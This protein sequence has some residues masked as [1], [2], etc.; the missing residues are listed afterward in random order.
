M[1]APPAPMTTTLN[2]ASWP[3]RS[4]EQWL[5]PSIVTRT[6]EGLLTSLSILALK[7]RQF[8]AS[9]A[10]S[11]PAAST[12][13]AA[14]VRKTR[15][16]PPRKRCGI[17]RRSN[18]A[19][20]RHREAPG[21]TLGSGVDVR[22]RR[23]GAVSRGAVAHDRDGTLPGAIPGAVRGV[24]RAGGVGD[25]GHPRASGGLRRLPAA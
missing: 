1:T 18:G 11:G 8:L 21:S 7:S 24:G 25:G 9:A 22:G 14:L 5:R 16:V 23:G 4:S 20:L 13:T 10:K 19:S 3:S 15:I 12:S 17:L 6:P 2:R